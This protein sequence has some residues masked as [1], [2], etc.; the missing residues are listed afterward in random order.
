MHPTHS[1]KTWLWLLLPVA[2]VQALGGALTATSVHGWYQTL[3]KSPLTPPD[4]VFGPV[5]TTLYL[6]L[7]IASARVWTRL[8]VGTWHERA[9]HPAMRCLWLHLGLNLL[10][11]A[12]FFGLQNPALALLD[13]A[14][15]FITIWANILL[16][17]R[18]DAVA[19]WLL[20]PMLGW[21]LFASWLNLHIVQHL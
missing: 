21:V 6:L 2:G 17:R 10:W 19:A 1:R 13:I 18:F 15:L 9:W 16:Y 8:P 4:W 12:L 5:W 20:A 7:W 3:P 11:S 14:A